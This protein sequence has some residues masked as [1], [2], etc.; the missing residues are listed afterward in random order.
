L[1]IRQLYRTGK[2]VYSGETELQVLLGLQNPIREDENTKKPSLLVIEADVKDLKNIQ[3]SCQFIDFMPK[4]RDFYLL[5][6]TAGNATNYSL[7]LSPSYNKITAKKK[8]EKKFSIKFDKITKI[9]N[10]KIDGKKVLEILSQDFPDEAAYIRAILE[11]IKKNPEPLYLK[12]EEFM[13]DK[14]IEKFNNPLIFKIYDASGSRHLGEIEAM[15]KLYVMIALPPSNNSYK[16][17]QCM[18]CGS[19]EQLQTGFDLGFFTLDQD[20]FRKLFFKMEKDLS[21]QFLM[22]RKCYIFSLLGFLTLENHLKFYSYSLK[23]GRKSIPVYHYLIPMAEDLTR[24]QEDIDLI[25]EA[26]ENRD[27]KKRKRMAI[28]I[29]DLD[30]QL[31][32]IKQKYQKEK[33]KKAKTAYKQKEKKL[34]EKK[35]QL[36]DSQKREIEKFPLEDF[37][38]EIQEKKK[39][40]PIT[41]LYFKITDQKSTPKR[42]DIIAEIKMSSEYASKL[43]KIFSSVFQSPNRT[44]NLLLLLKIFRENPQKFIFYHSSLLSLRSVARQNFMRDFAAE[45][46][47]DFIKHLVN[48]SSHADFNK[49]DYFRS[50]FKIFETYE[51]LFNEARLWKS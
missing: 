38:E 31:L 6:L 34:L 43:A 8:K 37:L 45:L 17:A 26:K 42:K 11:Q 4:N 15:K 9:L 1:L 7:S 48:I 12:I 33:E 50:N 46:K 30:N 23:D 24:L 27:K 51:A 21:F 36:K 47:S 16:D 13:D 44:S 40:I 29:Q 5:G 41:D 25:S 35:K 28:Q 32:Q 39:F 49:P 14:G 2:A 3:Y 10:E 19:T 22:C 20:G 18:I